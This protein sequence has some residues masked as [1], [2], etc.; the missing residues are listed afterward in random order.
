MKRWVLGIVVL[1]ALGAP[2][3]ADDLTGHERFLCAAGT[4]T[5]CGEDGVC[6]ETATFD[7]NVPHFVEVDLVQKRLSTTKASGENRVTE[8]RNLHREGG[9]VLL[10]GMDRGRAFSWL[11]RESTGLMTVAV[12]TDG[13]GITVFGSCTPMPASK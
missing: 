1:A 9:V 10:Q 12:A 6:L 8:I 5:A 7:L 3:L 11:I 13:F 2:A 4:V